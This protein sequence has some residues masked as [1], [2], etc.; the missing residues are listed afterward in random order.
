MGLQTHRYGKIKFDLIKLIIHDLQI[1]KSERL[2][3]D[4][5]AIRPES[6]SNMRLIYLI[7]QPLN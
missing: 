7:L 3:L 5:S 1:N 4:K 6:E 2:R